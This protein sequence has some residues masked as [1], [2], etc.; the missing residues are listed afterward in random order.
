M[1]WFIALILS[2]LTFGYLFAGS[3]NSAGHLSAEELRTYDAE[4]KSLETAITDDPENTGLQNR[5]VQLQRQMLS[6]KSQADTFAMSP[7]LTMAMIAA[8]S[9]TAI[10]LYFITGT[11]ELSNRTAPTQAQADQ[12]PQNVTLSELSE[13]MAARLAQDPDQPMGWV[14]YGRTLITLGKYDEGLAAYDKAADLDPENSDIA[15]ERDRAREF[16]AA[17]QS[18]PTPEQIQAAEN[19]SGDERQA[20]ILSMVEG[21]AARLADNPD[22]PEGWTRLLKARQ[23]L[24]QADRLEADIKTVED[25]FSDRPELRDQILS[26]AN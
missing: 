15:A 23:V 2:L 9:I 13:R 19:M 20:M 10:G 22:D 8:L 21:L 18:G 12:N 17:Q 6:T 4:I 1:I 11:P 5:L 14:L 16:A 26:A 3:K 7:R 24:G 25:I